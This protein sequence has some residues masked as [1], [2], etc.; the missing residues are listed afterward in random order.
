[1]KLRTKFQKWINLTVS[2]SVKS[3]KITRS[4][5][6]SLYLEPSCCFFLCWLVKSASCETPRDNYCSYLCH[7][8]M[9]MKKKQTLDT[10][11]HLHVVPLERVIKAVSKLAV[12]RIRLEHHPTGLMREGASRSMAACILCLHYNPHRAWGAALFREVA[13]VS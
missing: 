6:E 5:H 3:W 4:K 11:S 8:T 12:F 13:S 2:S 1:M 10:C 7:S 9:V